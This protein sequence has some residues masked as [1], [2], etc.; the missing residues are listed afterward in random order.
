MHQHDVGQRGTLNAAGNQLYAGSTINKEAGVDRSYE[1]S[2]DALKQQQE[3]D[4]A[5]WGREEQEAQHEREEGEEKA[6]QGAIEREEEREPEPQPGPAGARGDH[7]TGKAAG[8]FKPKVKK[9][10]KR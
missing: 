10:G 4:Q 7:P 8:P 3:A 1:Q 6:E 2:S 9:K 5:R